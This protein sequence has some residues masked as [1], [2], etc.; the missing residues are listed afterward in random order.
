MSVSP[1]C[2]YFVFGMMGLS[3]LWIMDLK[4]LLHREISI[5]YPFSNEY[6]WL[7]GDRLLLCVRGICPDYNIS[8]ATFIYHAST[9]ELTRLPTHEKIGIL[10]VTITGA[11]LYLEVTQSNTF[12]VRYTENIL[13]RLRGYEKW[14][15]DLQVSWVEWWNRAYFVGADKEYYLFMRPTKTLLR[16]RYG[17]FGDVMFPKRTTLIGRSGS[18]IYLKPFDVRYPCFAYDTNT[19]EI[20][21]LDLGDRR[22]CTLKISPDGQVVGK[23]TITGDFWIIDTKTGEHKKSII[24]KIRDFA[25]LPI[26][27]V[28]ILLAQTPIPIYSENEHHWP[29]VA[30]F[31]YD[32]DDFI[33]EIPK[34]SQ[35]RHRFYPARFRAR[36]LALLFC[37]QGVLPDE[38]VEEICMLLTPDY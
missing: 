16:S 26:P 17:F 32:Q 13:D 10:D 27:G 18:E 1:N 9:G 3:K 21:P 28:I 4:T 7:S 5:C 19:L 15:P 29:Y 20:N 34:W 31:D 12:V 6:Y 33:T 22:R 37:L 25:F 8:V 36:V 30:F 14:R 35:G 38:L 2:R 24:W 23:M 11:C